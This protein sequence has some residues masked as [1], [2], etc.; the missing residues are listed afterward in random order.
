ML[1][2][3]FFGP[4]FVVLLVVA[5]GYLWFR[6]A[7]TTT[8][9]TIEVAGIDGEVT[10]S[11]DADGIPRIKAGS[12][13]GVFFGL[14]FAHAQ[15]RLWQMDFHRRLGAGRL[16]EILGDRGLRFDR[17]MR[18]LGLYHLAEKSLSTLSKEARQAVDAYSAG[19][20]AFLTTRDGAWPIDF[21]LLHYRPEPW[22][23]ADSLVWSRMMAMR[24]GRNWRS[25]AERARLSSQLADLPAGR[26]DE[27]WPAAP[28]VPTVL[29]E[30]RHGVG[31][32]ELDR[33]GELAGEALAAMGEALGPLQA[34]NSWV[35]S[36]R[37]TTTGKPLLAGDPHL[38]FTAPNLWYLARLEAPGFLRVGA[39]VPGVPFLVL[40][41]NGHIAWS[42]TNAPSDTQDLFVER[43]APGKPDYYLAPGGP[44]R[45]ITRQEII[46][47]K[48]KPDVV[49]KVRLTRHGPVISDIHR[50]LVAGRKVDRVLALAAT[51]LREDDRTAEALYRFSA[52]RNWADF[53][54]AL[55][56]FHSPHQS[57]TYADTAGNIGFIAAG[58]VPIRKS[59]SGRVPVPGWTGA[60]DW[61]GVIPFDEL[62]QAL[63]PPAGRIVAANQRIVPDTYRYPM[64]S[65]W[66]PGYRA[67]RIHQ[68]LDSGAQHSSQT[69]ADMQ[70]DVVS[71][72]ARELLPLMLGVRP[73][74][75]RAAQA[76]D[77]LRQWDGKMDR[78]RPE[79]LVFT[80]WLR[81]LNRAVYGDELGA[82]F[83]DYWRLRPVFIRSVLTGKAHWCDDITTPARETC[84]GR[85]SQS[86]DAA[87]SWLVARHGEELKL[88]RWGNAHRARF[89]HPVLRYVPALGL[90]ARVDID[91]DGGATTLNRAN[92][93][94]ND[95]HTPFAAVHGAGYR[96]IYDLADLDASRFIQATG[97]SGNPLSGRYHNLTTRW[98]DG[99][100]LR[101]GPL[102][103]KAAKGGVLHLVPKK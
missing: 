33:L 82:D 53:R 21:Y 17:I 24:L 1:R 28:N 4:L 51:A 96:G 29:S 11:R 49:L 103:E 71:L 52:A 14:G 15:D 54:H 44:R 80:A 69:M 9:G 102:T 32:G 101:L 74:D 20:N 19:V 57:I 81:E 78:N 59:G 36:G 85:L 94:I 48:D 22:K 58:R 68:L 55:R 12:E 65:G 89:E 87:L 100:Y 3:V 70:L 79:P 92:M 10:I 18:T 7:L 83:I 46:H 45:F 40:G 38:G 50:H 43:I 97:Q 67:R 93:R 5:G 42:F 8:E 72:M 39:T 23:P 41:H 2:R 98:R 37:H 13:R 95:P 6:T 30:L 25:E 75:D 90:L 86:L 63:N 66:A 62:P 64:G 88:W 77:M 16:A 27:L 47:V 56:N 76:V 26:V 35:L 61:S 99:K 60:Y 31:D 91:A 73:L 84:A 34:S